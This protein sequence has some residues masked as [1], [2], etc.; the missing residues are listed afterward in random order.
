MTAISPASQ[1]AGPAD[2][3]VITGSGLNLG[4][5]VAFQS[6][7]AGAGSATYASQISVNAAGTELTVQ[8]DSQNMTPG[9]YDVILN[10]VGYTT[11]TAGPGYLPNAYTV[12]AAA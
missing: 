7:S 10:G 2:Q 6:E 5:Q 8:L 12:T 1:Q 3:I 9:E 11:G 4:T